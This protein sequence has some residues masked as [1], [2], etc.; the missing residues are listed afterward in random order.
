[1]NKFNIK[2]QDFSNKP[3]IVFSR[4]V[5]GFFKKG[6]LK[7]HEQSFNQMP[8]KQVGALKSLLNDFDTAFLAIMVLCN[9][10]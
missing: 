8:Y 7:E 9:F 2:D 5:L 3:S 6:P 10:A 1:M 4:Y